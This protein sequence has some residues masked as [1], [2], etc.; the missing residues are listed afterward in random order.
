[1]V[2]YSVTLY[3]FI[4]QYNLKDYNTTGS[5]LSKLHQYARTTI[6]Y[7]YFYALQEERKKS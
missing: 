4:R 1:M 3:F 5:K 6:L 7:M 2:L